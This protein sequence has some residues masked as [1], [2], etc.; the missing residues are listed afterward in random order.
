MWKNK[1][2]H[3]EYGE[4]HIILS[5]AMKINR[6]LKNQLMQK[7]I[8]QWMIKNSCRQ[9]LKNRHRVLSSEIKINW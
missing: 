1:V 5:S 6:L 9:T 7:Q 4:G 3:F 8:H 2:S